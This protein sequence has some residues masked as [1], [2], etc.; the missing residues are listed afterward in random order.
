MKPVLSILLIL[1]LL[2]GCAGLSADDHVSVTPHVEQ[3]DASGDDGTV[4]AEDYYNLRTAIM[5][6]VR[7]GRSSGRIRVLTY[8]GDVEKD[9]SDVV[10]SITKQDPLGAYAVDYMTY[11]CERIVSYYEIDVEIHYRRSFNQIASVKTV[12]GTAKLQELVRLAVDNCS[13]SLVVLVNSYWEQ[14]VPAMVESYRQENPEAV[15]EMPETLVTIYPETG[16]SRI[17]EIE[18]RWSDEPKVMLERKNAVTDSLDGAANYIRYRKTD[19]DKIRLLYQ[20]LTVRFQY[21]PGET[22]APLYAALCEGVAHPWGLSTAWQLIC[23]RAGIRCRTVSGQYQGQ[24][25]TWNALCLDDVW[26][27]LDL[28]RCITEDTGLILLDDAAMTD[29]TVP[30]E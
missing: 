16:A 7:T 13:T 27:Y 26:Y 3:D 9:I 11:T 4:L 24:D 14:D 28:Y 5:E 22:N 18:F 8:D 19:M 25:H 10:Y 20:Y 30:A 15:P 12:G 29:Y 6:M 17:M 23:D 21:E 2:T 1:L